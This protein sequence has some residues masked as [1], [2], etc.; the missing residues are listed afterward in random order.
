MQIFVSPYIYI[1][2]F[3]KYENA[4][5]GRAYINL[6]I[7]LDILIQILKLYTMNYAL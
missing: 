4:L 7:L 6:N 2:K 1:F 3:R 5:K